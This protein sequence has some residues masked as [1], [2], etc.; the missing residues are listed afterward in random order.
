M[1]DLYS[2]RDLLLKMDVKIDKLLESDARNKERFKQGAVHFQKLDEKDE[3]QDGRIDGLES[4]RC[5]KVPSYKIVYAL[6][7]SGIAF[8]SV[9]VALGG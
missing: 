7:I 8:I 6:I 9:L 2:A 1:N 3:Q 5:P 4:R